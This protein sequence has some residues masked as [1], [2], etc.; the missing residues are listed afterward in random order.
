VSSTETI[1]AIAAAT[2]YANSALASTTY[3]IT[4]PAAAPVFSVNAGIYNSVQSVTISDTTTGAVIYYT[5]NG[6]TPTSASTKYTGAITVSSAETLEAIATATGYSESPVTTAAYTITLPAA[7]PAFSVAT[8]TY[9]T[10]QT[11]S[12]TDATAGST[13][14]YTTDGTTPTTSSTQYTG[15]LTVSATETVEAIAI[16]AGYSSSA[17]ATA[18]YTINLPVPGFSLTVSPSSLTIPAGQSGT[19]TITVS[20]TNGFAAITAFSCTGLPAGATCSFSPSSVQPTGAPASTTLTISAPATANSG[21]R[22]G[23]PGSFP[24]ATLALV[25]CC[26]GWRKRRRI[27]DLL[28][29]IA[30]SLLGVTVLIGCGGSSK[31][32]PVTSN[33]SVV[34]TSGSIQ[35]TIPITITIQ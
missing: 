6:T 5:T 29:V 22:P 12:I 25:L 2:G 14:Y 9:T 11:V 10:V 27:Q 4:P 26:M 21:H 23:L 34:A 31:P 28:A 3:T 19:A 24:G 32:K 1:K 16:A 33:V 8:G 35:Q 30:I 13:I 15:A 17:V 7:T 20:P 18:A